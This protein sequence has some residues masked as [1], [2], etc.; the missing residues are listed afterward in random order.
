MIRNT[1]MHALRE[2]VRHPVHSLPINFIYE[3]PSV[4]ALASFVHQ[5][6]T[7]GG[8]SGSGRESEQALKVAEMEQLLNHFTHYLNERSPGIQKRAFDNNLNSGCTPS[9]DEVVVITGTTGYLG[10]FL[11]EQTIR[12]GRVRKIYA[13]NRDSSTSGVTVVDRQRDAFRSLSI[14]PV[15]LDDPKIDFVAADYPSERL[16]LTA[17][18]YEEICAS[19]TT[20]IHNG[21]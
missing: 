14:D 8:V 17:D 4:A 10:S 7:T 13:L 15:L 6:S 12:D 3:H 2:T 21:T 18:K 19:A 5:W 16:G 20:I 11:L 9:A 1:I